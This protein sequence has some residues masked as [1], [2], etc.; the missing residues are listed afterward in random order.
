M[1]EAGFA[2]TGDLD[3]ETAADVGRELLE[4]VER[5]DRSPVVVDCSSLGFLDS[6]GLNMLVFVRNTSG[7]EIELRH[8]PERARR[9]FELTALDSVFRLA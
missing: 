6:S 2:L 8:V 4:H 3:L 1:N 7:K 9:V 5:S